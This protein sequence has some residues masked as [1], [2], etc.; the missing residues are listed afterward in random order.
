MTSPLLPS[1]AVTDLAISGNR[2]SIPD[3]TAKLLFISRETNPS[4]RSP[5]SISVTLEMYDGEIQSKILPAD[6]PSTI[7]TAL[8]IRR[9]AN[10]E[11]IPQPNY[12]PTYAELSPE[13][14]WVYLNW[15]MNITQPINIGYVFLY[16][17]G[18]ERQLLTGEFDDAFDEIIILRQTHTDNLSFDTYSRAALLISAIFKKR[19][20]RL[21]QI[22]RLFKPKHFSNTELLLAHRLGYDLGTEGLVRLAPNLR[23]VQKRYIKNNS[24]EYERALLGVL[25]EE[26]GT[27]YMPFSSVYKISEM[28]K[29]QYPLF[30]NS[31]FPS[32]IRI[33]ET[34]SVIDYPPFVD[35]AVRILNL[36]HERVK[37]ELANIRKQKRS[38]NQ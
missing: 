15:L 3:H 4:F 6:E 5:R 11:L 21:E 34:P 37:Q 29:R 35:E 24:D 1:N 32:E 20:D 17:Y 26:Y 23:D 16:Y 36:A 10:P 30:A 22:Y 13:Q 31:S 2:L 18:L 12:Y 8:P 9:P 14:K 7:Y 38:G 28:Q 33:P 19:V 25:M 27:P